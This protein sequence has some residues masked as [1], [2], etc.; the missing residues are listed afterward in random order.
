LVRELLE[1][2]AFSSIL[3][4]QIGAGFEARVSDKQGFAWGAGTIVPSGQ[5]K[6]NA[7]KRNAHSEP[8]G[9]K[10]IQC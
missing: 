8:K 5:T 9:C 4:P 6:Q 7:I 3:F 10:P 2:A 1:T